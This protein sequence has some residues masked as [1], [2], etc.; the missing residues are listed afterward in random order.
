[1]CTHSLRPNSKDPRCTI[2]ALSFG[3]RPG[4]GRAV[5]RALHISCHSCAHLTIFLFR[6]TLRLFFLELIQPCKLTVK[7]SEHKSLIMLTYERDKNTTIISMRINLDPDL[8]VSFPCQNKSF[9]TSCVEVSLS[10][11]SLSTL[12]RKLQ[13]VF[14]LLIYFWGGVRKAF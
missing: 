10:H 2:S 8:A 13:S 3:P 4:K 11:T 12:A 14:T 1:M 6:F 5:S 7:I 9:S